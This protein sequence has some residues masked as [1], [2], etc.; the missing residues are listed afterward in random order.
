MKVVIQCAGRKK[1]TA[2][3]L[4]AGDGRE[5]SFVAHPPAQTTDLRVLAR[6]D[7]L[8]PDGRSWR[9]HLVE[10][11]ASPASNQLGLLPAYELYDRP[12]YQDLRQ[13]FGVSSLFILSAGWGVVPAAFLLPDYNIT[14]SSSAPREFRRRRADPFNDW[15]L[16]STAEDPLLFLGGKDYLP[17][18]A[19]LTAQYRGP[20]IALFNSTIPPAVDGLTFVRYETTARTNWHYLAADALTRGTLAL[21]DVS[22][23]ATSLSN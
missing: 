9:E 6:P 11:N 10:Y 14:F 18:F 2:G 21:P 1:Q 15:P 8:A 16:I 22:S 12:V 7:D 23:G 20:R 5:V 19:S 3:T 4:V 17:H 13:A